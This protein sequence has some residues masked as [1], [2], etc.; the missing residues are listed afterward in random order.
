MNTWSAHVAILRL[1][2]HFIR[3]LLIFNLA[4]EQVKAIVNVRSLIWHPIC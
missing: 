3:T 1:T 2:L 4:D